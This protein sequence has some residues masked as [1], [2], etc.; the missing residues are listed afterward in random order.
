MI[1]MK[2]A[3]LVGIA[4]VAVGCSKFSMHRVD[5]I[6]GNYIEQTRLDNLKLGMTKP[7]VQLLLGTPLVLDVYDPDVW[8]Y[9]FFHSD[10]D[11]AVKRERTLKLHFDQNGRYQFLEDDSAADVP[12]E[13]ISIAEVV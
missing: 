11:G 3:L 2:Y 1:K 10:S 8:Y 6:Q 5:V 12:V 13:D 7:E 9:V 4:L